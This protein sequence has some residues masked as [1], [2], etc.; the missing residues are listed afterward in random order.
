MKTYNFTKRAFLQHFLSRS[1][2]G[3]VLSTDKLQGSK[4]CSTRDV[5]V[6]TPVWHLFIIP[7][8]YLSYE[9]K[10][11]CKTREYFILL[12]FHVYYSILTSCLLMQGTCMEQKW[13]CAESIF[14]TLLAA[15]ISSCQSNRFMLLTFGS[16]GQPSWAFSTSSGRYVCYYR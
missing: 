1:K 14:A 7:L 5:H 3:G 6:K 8:L 12:F 13:S 4:L 11:A 9:L 15:N 10:N 2:Y 16:R